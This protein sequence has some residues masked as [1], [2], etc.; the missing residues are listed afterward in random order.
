MDNYDKY[1]VVNIPL[2]LLKNYKD[3]GLSESLLIDFIHL[4]SF[5][6]KLIDFTKINEV[7]VISRQVLSE[8]SRLELI[9]LQEI[10]S[11]LYIDISP[12]YDIIYNEK[13]ANNQLLNAQSL[14]R[15]SLILNRKIKAHEIEIITEWLK[16]GYSSSE[17][18]LAMQKSVINNVDN[19]K[20]IEKVLFNEPEQQISS[21]TIER[22]FDLFTN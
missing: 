7:K 4:L 19:M 13:I 10:D 12:S 6:S 8:L 14:D 9:K 5:S 17:I 1:K 3:F 22:N 18:E 15:F 20:Y 2:G 21:T 16:N 11:R